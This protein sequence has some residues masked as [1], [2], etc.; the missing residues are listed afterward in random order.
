MSEYDVYLEPDSVFKQYAP[1]RKTIF[2]R[3]HNQMRSYVDKDELISVIN[4]Q[5]YKLVQEYNSQRGIDFPCYIKK[6]LPLRV[7][8]FVTKHQRDTTRELITIEENSDV[9][10]NVEDQEYNKIL[11]YIIDMN[12][13][14]NSIKLGKKHRS[15][16]IGLLVDKKTIRELAA[17]EGVPTDIIHARLY[18]LIK[19]FRDEYSRLKESY[20]EELY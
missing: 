5:F 4:E 3:F 15:L 9:F 14:D 12:S 8:H 17:D 1:F 20:G 19:K 16:M 18:F 6:M 10:V 7:Y 11:Q 13:I 2:K